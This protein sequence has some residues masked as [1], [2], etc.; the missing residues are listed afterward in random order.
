MAQTLMRS[1]GVIM[2]QELL[3]GPAQRLL[4]EKKNPRQ[5]FLFDGAKKSFDVSVA[6]WTLRR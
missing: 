4:P 2:D 3:D 6:I 5:G 1:F